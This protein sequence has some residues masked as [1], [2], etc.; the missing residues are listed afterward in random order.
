MKKRLQQPLAILLTILIAFSALVSTGTV[1]N[2]AG[3]PQTLASWGITVLPTPGSIPA[4]GGAQK[5]SGAYLTSNTGKAWGY[6]T[7]SLNTTGWD[8]GAGSKFWEISLSSKGFDSLK[9]SAQ[10]RSSATGPRDWKVQ[11]STD[12]IQ[13]TD[14]GGSNYSLGGG[15]QD[16]RLK[17]WMPDLTLPSEACNQATLKIRLILAS[18]KS[19]K[20]QDIASAGVSNINNVFIKGTPVTDESVVNGV[21]AE[22]ASGSAVAIGKALSLSCATADATIIYKINGGDE[23]TY[24]SANKP[25]LDVLPA[26]VVAYATKDGMTDSASATFQYTQAIVDSVTAKPNGGSVKI[27]DLITLKCETAD[28]HITYSIDDGT[29]WIPYSAP[30]A[31]TKLP[32]TVLAKATAAGMT[33]SPQASFVFNERVNEDYNI[34]FGQLHSHTTNSDGIGTVTEAFEHASKVDGLDLSLIHI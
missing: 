3:V 19:L 15:T 17:N 31:V 16:T 33:D 32:T 28:S 27:G 22:P 20:D 5:D 29:T 21:V 7:A 34:Y 2:A 11:Y 23:Q 30:F 13:F 12:G 14:V 26:T 8:N 6:A 10:T 1:A 25:I 24:D 9:L 18:N 4:T